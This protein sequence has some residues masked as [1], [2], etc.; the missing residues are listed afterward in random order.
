MKSGWEYEIILI[1][2]GTLINQ[3]FR[4]RSNHTRNFTTG[5]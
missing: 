5:I 1:I 4:S 3:V 2:K